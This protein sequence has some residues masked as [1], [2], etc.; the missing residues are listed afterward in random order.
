MA[1][2][3]ASEVRQLWLEQREI[4]L[5]D[6]REEGPYSEG[7]PFFAI[8]VPISEVEE[9]LPL[10]VPRISCPIVVY[11][12]G[13]NY[14]HRAIQRMKNL[15][16]TEVRPLAGGLAGYAEV[17][18]V[19]RDVNSACKAFGE[20]VEAIQH[21]PSLPAREMKKLL[22]SEE[23]VVVLD[24]RRYAEYNTMSIMRGRSCP[25]GELV[26]RIHDVAPSPETTVIVNCAGRTRSIVGTQSLI[27]AG[28][29]NKVM[30]LRNGTIGWTLAGLE[31]ERGKTD[32]IAEPTD[33]AQ[34]IARERAQAWARRV[35]VSTISKEVLSSFVAE[36]DSRTLYLLDVRDPEE[37]A[38]SHPHGCISAPGGQLVQ[39]TD[40]WVGVRGA[41]L[42]LFDNDG[43][44]AL[45]AASWLVQMGWDAVV[46]ERGTG[47]PASTTTILRPKWNLP[48]ENA[49]SPKELRALK[50]VSVVDLARSPEYRSSHIPCAYHCSG[51]E[52]KRD[53]QRLPST[54]L[55]VLT[56]TDGRIA[57]ANLVEAG[58]STLTMVKYL[59]GGTKAWCAEGYPLE[60][61]GR[62]LSDPIDV[63]K[64]P[65]EGTDN[66]KA[67]MQ[68]YIDWE[69][70][71][72]AQ[73]ANDGI[74]GF[75][76]VRK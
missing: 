24:A 28:I 11:D 18:E 74:C 57:A 33:H 30:A 5:V 70:Q 48:E 75:H 7:H 50:H 51:P 66:A 12:N 69:L 36:S 27:N 71:L 31:V 54:N 20:L 17:G 23:D 15:G 46:L 67:N 49:I 52:L 2:I 56:S 58:A 37:Y 76:V 38:A 29:P 44:R 16:Y 13:E 3:S 19:F 43:V 1:S 21:T 32:R 45:M 53:L 47:F 64:R 42:V 22:E 61:E 6:V 59:S 62:W 73:L 55:I 9:K 68:A 25:G 65:Y 41:R 34:A 63:Y 4:A 40:E 39:A 10:L 72:I 8:S 60:Q 26:Y 14:T 35:G